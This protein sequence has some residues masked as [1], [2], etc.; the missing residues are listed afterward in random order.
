MSYPASEWWPCNPRRRTP[1][2]EFL[3]EF[4]HDSQKSGI[5]QI[6]LCVTFA[7]EME[8]REPFRA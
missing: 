6:G 7:T 8:L 2:L 3:R 4:F 5:A 1:T